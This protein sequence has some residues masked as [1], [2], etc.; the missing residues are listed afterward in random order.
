M[1]S[2]ALI[3]KPIRHM[4]AMFSKSIEQLGGTQ[5]APVPE[6]WVDAVEDGAAGGKK[7]VVHD[8]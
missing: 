6:A 2:L 1:T 7:G 4:L 8:F 3:S 5:E